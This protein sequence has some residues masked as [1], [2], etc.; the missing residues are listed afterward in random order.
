MSETCKKVYFIPLYENVGT[1]NNDIEIIRKAPTEIIGDKTVTHLVL[2]DLKLEVEGVFIIKETVSPEQLVP[3]LEMDGHH[4]KVDR[5][6]MTNIEGIYAAGDCSGKPY[7][8]SKAAG[9][10]QTAGLHAVG[11]VDKKIQANLKNSDSK[12][13]V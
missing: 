11:Y 6:M 8:L 13:G 5:N 10:G 3:G 4:I 12:V 2:E 7:Q 1:L 9:E